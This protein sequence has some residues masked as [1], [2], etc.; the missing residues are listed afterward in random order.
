MRRNRPVDID[1]IM[2]EGTLVDREVR[3][4]VREALLFHKRTGNPV[5]EW[6]DG[7]VVVIPPEKIPV[8]DGASRR[9]TRG[10]RRARR[11]S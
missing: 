1:K 3:K 8:G 5:C 7:R 9:R 6:R 4:A 10:K 2:A 11:R